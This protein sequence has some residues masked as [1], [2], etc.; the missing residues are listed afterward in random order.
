MET[1]VY[2]LVHELACQ[3]WW[4][5]G[6]EAVI[7]ALLGKVGLPER[8][9]VLDAGC[10]AGQNMQLYSRLGATEGFDPSPEAVAYCRRR[11]LDNVR[12]GT[13]EE[14]PFEA[15]S[16]DLLTATDVLEHVADDGRGMRELSRVAA[17]G[18]SL[19]LTVPAYGWMWTD[20]DVRLGHMR[21]YTRPALRALVRRNGWEPTFDTYF[22][23]VL[24]APIASARKLRQSLGSRESAELALTPRALDELLS[25]P[26]RLEARLIA[27]GL[28]IPAGVSVGLV[29][30]AV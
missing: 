29:C 15:S 24:L 30:R 9:R 25:L 28:S 13:M 27:A 11:G 7:T 16:F 18:A 1:D 2:R 5:R 20:E 17:P 23:T 10:G 8:P 3:H 12:Q 14:I 19:I 21:R 4:F 26:M 22:N 6:R